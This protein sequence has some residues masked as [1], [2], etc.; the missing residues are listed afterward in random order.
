MSIQGSENSMNK[1]PD[2]QET[3]AKVR[4]A[5]EEYAKGGADKATAEYMYFNANEKI[6]AYRD[7]LVKFELSRADN[8]LKF[9]HKVKNPTDF[10]I[11]EIDAAFKEMLA[12]N[13]HRERITDKYQTYTTSPFFKAIMPGSMVDSPIYN[14]E[15]VK[16]IMLSDEFTKYKAFTN[17]VYKVFTKDLQIADVLKEAG[18][19]PLNLNQEQ[20]KEQALSELLHFMPKSF[21]PILANGISGV[22]HDEKTQKVT[23][24]IVTSGYESKK[25]ISQRTPT[26]KRL[27]PSQKRLIYDFILYWLDYYIRID[28]K[29]GFPTPIWDFRDVRAKAYLKLSSIINPYPGKAPAKPKR[30]PETN[31]PAIKLPALIQDKVVLDGYTQIEQ[32]ISRATNVESREINLFETRNRGHRFKDGSIAKIFL[33]GA[34]DDPILI[35]NLMKN[36]ARILSAE[37]RELVNTHPGKTEFVITARQA[38]KLVYGKDPTSKEAVDNLGVMLA[39]IASMQA[40]ILLST[41]SIKHNARERRSDLETFNAEMEKALRGEIELRPFFPCAVIRDEKTHEFL[42]LRIIGVSVPHFLAEIKGQIQTNY[43]EET[44]TKGEASELSANTMHCIEDYINRALHDFIQSGRDGYEKLFFYSSVYQY[45]YDYGDGTTQQTMTK[46]QEQRA[47]ELIKK[48]F[49]EITEDMEG[50]RS[51]IRKDRKTRRNRFFKVRV[52]LDDKGNVIETKRGK[53]IEVMITEQYPQ[54]EKQK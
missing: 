48:R 24:I 10:L 2:N 42:K 43:L 13:Q 14:P 32:R 52:P 47:R 40:I 50:S 44:T 23:E 39:Q 51:Y 19:R 18:K 36:A 33:P 17:F 6:A 29:T 12:S 16:N 27:S 38:Y 4:A 3:R 9:S 11:G 15:T 1:A 21:E 28:P 25:N 45:I 26:S 46:R 34:P 54:K 30:E 5:L 8:V 35:T 7:K 31:Q 37:Y 53:C 20:T 49:K 41:Y 22:K